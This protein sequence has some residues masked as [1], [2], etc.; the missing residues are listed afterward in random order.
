M[1]DGNLRIDI[2]S[3]TLG[4]IEE[5]EEI[6][7]VSFTNLAGQLASG[8]VPMRF[9]TAIAYLVRRRQEPGYTLDDARRLQL[10]DLEDIFGGRVEAGAADPTPPPSGSGGE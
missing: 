8:D 7:G 2:E 1:A 9:V 5:L 10:T 4:E 6:A 3:M